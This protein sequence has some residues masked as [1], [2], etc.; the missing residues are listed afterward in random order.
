VAAICGLLA[1]L[2][3]TMGWLVADFVQPAG[4]SSADDDISDLGAKTATSPWIH[5]Q[6][7]ANLTGILVLVFALGLWRSVSPDLL[8]RLGAGG[9]ILLGL[10]QFLRGFS[11]WTVRG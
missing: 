4:F 8:G 2:T 11:G 3:Y 6:V 5:N 1:S 10:A 7:G 9:L